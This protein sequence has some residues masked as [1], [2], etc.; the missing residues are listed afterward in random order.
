MRAIGRFVDMAGDW[1][2]AFLR[3]TLERAAR[4]ALRWGLSMGLSFLV[5]ASLAITA[6]VFIFSA[7]SNVL[8]ELGVPLWASQLIL[9]SVSALIA[10][11]FYWRAR[12][13]R[14]REEYEK[15]EKDV[16][17][18]GVR[19]RIVRAP[20]PASRRRRIQEE[21]F[22]VHPRPNSDG[23]E[24]TSSDSALREPYSTKEAAVKGARR[25]AR[26]RG[27]VIVHRSSGEIDRDVRSRRP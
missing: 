10:L 22:D 18:P 5:A 6:A 4:P 1:A 25:K 9:G 7:L 27:R 21:V 8:V 23:W 12:G 24:V 19:I 14:L 17:P 16:E 11:V 13:K 20:R 15:A 2:L 3:G 26:G